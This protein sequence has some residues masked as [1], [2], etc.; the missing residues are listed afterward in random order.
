MAYVRTTSFRLSRDE[1]N[2]VLPG[3]HIYNALVPA[4]KFIAQTIDGLVQTAVLR[5]TNASGDLNFVIFTEWSTLEDLQNYANHPD[6][7][8]IENF[9]NSEE[10]PIQINIYEAI[11]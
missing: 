7:V 11:G 5:S 3:F 10:H 9:L 1:G 4:R 6:I 2:K 8:E